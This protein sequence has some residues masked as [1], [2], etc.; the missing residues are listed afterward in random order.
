MFLE[1]S[2]Q[3]YL[4]LRFFQ[5]ASRMRRSCVSNYIV[6]LVYFEKKWRFPLDRNLSILVIKIISELKKLIQT[7]MLYKK[8]KSLLDAMTSWHVAMHLGKWMM[9]LFCI[10][11]GHNCNLCINKFEMF[12]EVK[13][14]ITN[15]KQVLLFLSE[16][17]EWNNLKILCLLRRL[18]FISICQLHLWESENFTHKSA[19]SRSCL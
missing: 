5:S 16:S 2:L 12:R 17:R 14:A 6:V 15:N 4:I 8:R 3:K 13:P 7:K 19:D 10:L 11:T 18:I 9:K 1:F